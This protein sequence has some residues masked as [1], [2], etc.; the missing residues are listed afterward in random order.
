[1]TIG[2]TEA[3]IDDITIEGNTFPVGGVLGVFYLNNSGEYTCAGSVIW[4]YQANAIPVWSSDDLLEGQSLTI[5]AFASGVA[6]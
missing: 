5:F 2:V 4:D 1:M 3:V 6:V